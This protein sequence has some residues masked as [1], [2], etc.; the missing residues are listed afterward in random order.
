MPQHK[1]CAHQRVVVSDLS[2][3]MIARQTALT[4][5]DMIRILLGLGVVSALAL[6]SYALFPGETAPVPQQKTALARTANHKEIHEVSHKE[7]HKHFHPRSESVP[8]LDEKTAHELGRFDLAFLS[9]CCSRHGNR[10]QRQFFASHANYLGKGTLSRTAIEGRMM[11]FDSFW[12]KRKYT[13]KG[14]PVIAGPFDGDRYSV[15]QSFAWTLS[16][17]PWESKGVGV[18]HLRIRSL[19]TGQFE[20]LSMMEKEHL[21]GYSPRY[22]GHGF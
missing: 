12:P 13:A 22:F 16:N 18:L 9:A 4:R 21:F 20:I 3:R 2:L 8:Q 15:K 19:A 7:T 17:G 1:V 5:G 10:D 14:K 11:Q 6:E